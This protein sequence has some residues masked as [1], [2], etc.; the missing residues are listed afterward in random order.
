[1]PRSGTSTSGASIPKCRTKIRSRRI[2]NVNN[3]GAQSKCS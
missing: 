3:S 1:M 2:R